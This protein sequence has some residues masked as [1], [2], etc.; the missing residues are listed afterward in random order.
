M[1][2]HAA[3]KLH[4]EVA[5]ADGPLGGLAHDGEDLRQDFEHRLFALLA[6]FDRAD[7]RLPFG[8]FGAQFVVAQRGDLRLEPVDLIHVGTEPFDFAF[9]LRAEDFSRDEGKS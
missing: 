5:L 1:Q 4:V 2:D 8:D 7:I 6:V 9:V 3:D